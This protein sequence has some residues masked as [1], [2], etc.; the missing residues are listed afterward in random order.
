L[1]CSPRG[2]SRPNSKSRTSWQESLSTAKRRSR[3]GSLK[4][5][6][7]SICPRRN[8]NPRRRK[9][10]CEN[11][12]ADD[13]RRWRLDHAVFSPARP[14]MRRMDRRLGR[15]VEPRSCC[16]ALKVGPRRCIIALDVT[17]ADKAPH[18]RRPMEHCPLNVF[19]FSSRL[20]L[21]GYTYLG[22][23]LQRSET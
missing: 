20:M 6:D 1:K 18:H 11:R 7:I 23:H 2:A 14:S 16:D 17:D 9:G 10:L 21:S 15:T 13:P 22:G 5:L 8:A 19:L 12:D 4:F 3:S